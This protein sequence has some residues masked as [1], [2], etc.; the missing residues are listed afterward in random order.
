MMMVTTM[1]I[2]IMTTMK[3]LLLKVTFLVM[4]MVMLMM[5]KQI[6]LHSGG[7]DVD[8]YGIDL[9][10]V[11]LY[12]G[13]GVDDIFVIVQEWDNIRAEK[14]ISK[15]EKNIPEEVGLALKEAVCYFKL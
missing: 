5:L 2:A 6:F 11:F 4:T 10:N 9:N 3:I 12:S 1:F 7:V 8:D 14:K 13:I 15:Q